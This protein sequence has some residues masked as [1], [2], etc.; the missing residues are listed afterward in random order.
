[1][2]EVGQ[3]CTVKCSRYVEYDIKK[4]DLIYVAGEMMTAVKEED[5]YLYRKIFVAAYVNEEH[6]DAERKPI[7]IDGI[8]LKPVGKVRQKKL[9]GIFEDDFAEESGDDD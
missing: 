7:S 3:F 1:M 5:P 4:G 2:V 9:Y 6:V 8:N